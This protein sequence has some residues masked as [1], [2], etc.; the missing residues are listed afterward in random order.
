[1][2]GVGNVP[3]LRFPGFEGD[4]EER[5]FKDLYD[6][7]SSKRVYQD[8]WK[9]KGIPFYRARE[10]A[11]MSEGGHP[12]KIIYISEALYDEYA[13]HF[14]AIEQNDILVTG[15][16]TLGKAYVVKSNDRF[17]FKDGNIIWF[18]NKNKANSIFIKLLFSNQSI[19]KQVFDNAGGSTVGTY[20]IEEAKNTKVTIPSNAEQTKIADFLGLIDKKI[21][22]Q[23]EKVSA[24]EQY[25]KGL[26]Q[27]IFSRRIRFKNDKG[28]DYPE[29]ESSALGVIANILMGQSPSSKTYNQTNIG[30][31]L[32]QGNA[33]IVNR[34][35]N[36]TRFTNEPTKVCNKGDLLM[37]VRAPVGY[38]GKADHNACI[39]R[40]VCAIQP[41]QNNEYLYQYLLFIEKNWRN[42]EQ[43]STFTAVGRTDVSKIAIP[44]PTLPEQ[45]KIANFLSLY[46]RKIEKE[47]G[48]L[49]ALREQKKGLLQQMFV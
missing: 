11:I 15:V 43:G 9:S 25:K 47:K 39:G 48:K 16:G 8:Q 38:I 36:P 30:V 22:K 34:K 24:L 17:Y 4:W 23:D 2:S 35:T 27:K 3:K 28:K 12:S 40:G 41:K 19:I 21:T 26:M 14:G 31:P 20:T 13:R 37:T 46:D 45:T 10:I 1:M 33:D 5:K 18:K 29:W 32:I 44:H 7:T 42:I 6:V 49:E